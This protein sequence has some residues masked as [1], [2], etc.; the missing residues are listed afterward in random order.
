MIGPGRERPH[1]LRPRI[2]TIR[3][4]LV[5]R[6]FAG[7]GVSHVGL[8]ITAG[9]T[10]KTLR[11]H[12]IWADAWPIQTADKLAARLRHTDRCATERGEV[13]PTHVILSAPWIATGQ[14]A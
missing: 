2:E 10:A 12:G 13:R 4:A 11:R 14:L 3:V 6:D 8:G 1:H 7:H 9:H 5:Y